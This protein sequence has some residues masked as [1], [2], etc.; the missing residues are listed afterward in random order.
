MCVE[1]DDI[2]H[3]SGIET[4]D[5]EKFFFSNEVYRDTT[6]V[7]GQKVYGSVNDYYREISCGLFHFEGKVFD[8][9]QLRKKRAD[10]AQGTVNQRTR[11]EFF[12]EA[13]D[14]LA[15]REGS[16]VLKQFDGDGAVIGR[17]GA[18]REI[19]DAVTSR[20]ELATREEQFRLLAERRFGPF[21]GVQFLGAMNDNVFKQLVLQLQRIGFIG[22][23]ASVL[24]VAELDAL[25]KV[26]GQLGF[27]VV[28]HPLQGLD[29]VAGA[30]AA[31][32]KDGLLVDVRNN[33]GGHANHTMFWQ[34][35]A[36]GG[37]G[38][39]HDSPG[40]RG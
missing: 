15:A 14:A 26:A 27:A 39:G 8:C 32:G 19:D 7:T 9:V 16:N 3:N 1:F 5:W 22:T 30:V 29:D 21:F 28:H 18:W 12:S 40:G 35:M 25:R 2:K 20:E 13:F 4:D 24:A 11:S 38:F 10:Y 34:I 36:P 37:G 17:T 23:T 33:G 31:S 6:N